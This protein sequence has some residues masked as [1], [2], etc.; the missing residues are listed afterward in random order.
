MG[1]EKL[2]FDFSSSALSADQVAMVEQMV[3]ECILGN[4]PVSWSELP[5]SEVKGRPGILQFFGDKYGDTVRVVQIGG[6]RGSLDGGR[7]WSSCWLVEESEKNR[8]RDAL[9]LI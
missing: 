8:A 3:N 1:P 6:T 2:S 5:F 4:A 9:F 7:E